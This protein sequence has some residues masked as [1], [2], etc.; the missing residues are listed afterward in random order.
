MGAKTHCTATI[1]KR[2]LVIQAVGD[3]SVS[4][5]R[6]FLQQR[7]G[8]LHLRRTARLGYPASTNNSTD[9]VHKD[10]TDVA[11]HRL[12]ARAFLEQFGV[13]VGCALV[14]SVRT[15][16]TPEVG[17]VIIRSIGCLEAF[18]GCPR[19]DQGSVYHETITVKQ[20]T[21]L[22]NPDNFAKKCLGSAIG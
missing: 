17:L 2:V 3:G 14:G 13:F 4:G 9:S 1:N 20:M 16:R 12:L 22:C 19:L 5:F 15:F 6:V 21:L 11:Q 10:M 8:R 18:H 7:E